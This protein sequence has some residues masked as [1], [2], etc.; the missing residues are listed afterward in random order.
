[1]VSA[2]TRTELERLLAD[3]VPFGDLT[4]DALGIGDRPG[5]MAFFARDSMI[6]AEAESAAAILEIAGCRASLATR[7]GAA[8]AAGAPILT[9]VGSASAL[10]RG[11][12]VAQTLIEVW[13]GVA[14]AAR[15]LVDVVAAISPDVTVACTRKNVPGAKSYAVRAVRAGGAVMHRLGLSETVLVFPE[16][17]AFLGAEPIGETV[18][19]LRR[20]VP[21]KKLV[22]EVTSIEDA[23]AAADASFD[24]IQTEK[25]HPCAGC[26]AHHAPEGQG[27]TPPCRGGRWHQRRQCSCLCGGR[28]RHPG[29]VGA[30]SRA[31]VRCSGESDAGGHNRPCIQSCLI[32]ISCFLRA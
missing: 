3:D 16:H 2:A 6:V 11:W 18:S 15:A 27:S 24:V 20:A 29:H 4:T 5:E 30:I 26:G 14:T 21:E 10:H 23:V 13:S 12:K 32:S 8:L 7:S 31:T 17:R 19:R 1:M 9:A 25:I 28:R 22:I